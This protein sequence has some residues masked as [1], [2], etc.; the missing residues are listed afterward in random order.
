[1]VLKCVLYAIILVVLVLLEVL[2]GVRA[3]LLP[4]NESEYQVIL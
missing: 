1:M 4:Q 2:K 3:A